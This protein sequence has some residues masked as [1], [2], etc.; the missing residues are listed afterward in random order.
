MN[1]FHIRRDPGEIA[2]KLDRVLSDP[3][4][5]ARIREGGLATANDYAWHKV[6]ERYL[7]LFDELAAERAKKQHG[8]VDQEKIYQSD[9][10]LKTRDPI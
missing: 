9:G 7:R 4:L 8:F 3:E 10:P 1:G 2:A 5:H 6:A